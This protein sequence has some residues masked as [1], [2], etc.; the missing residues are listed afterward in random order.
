[1]ISISKGKAYGFI[2]NSNPIRSLCNRIKV[3]QFPGDKLSKQQQKNKKLK[4]PCF[5]TILVPSISRTLCSQGLL[6][7]PG[8]SLPFLCPACQRW[9]MNKENKEAM[10]PRIL[11]S[12]V[13]EVTIS[14]VNHGKLQKNHGKAQE[15][16]VS[17]K[18]LMW[19]WV[20]RI[21]HSCLAYGANFL[22]ILG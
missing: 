12:L 2:W 1:M 9:H 21:L 8:Y 15:L 10:W 18:I 22:G 6:K 4:P 11:Y 17:N 7:C 3:L 5:G 13:H 16:A 20:F 14:D 19:Y